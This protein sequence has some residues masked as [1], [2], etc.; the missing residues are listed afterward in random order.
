[1]ANVN[2]E[3]N[4][5]RE[6]PVGWF[7]AIFDVA[8]V[9]TRGGVNGQRRPNVSAEYRLLLNEAQL[10]AWPAMLDPDSGAASRR[11]RC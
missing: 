2:G 5:F 4:D 6:I 10:D 1:M 8:L 9:A 7:A 11:D 3:E